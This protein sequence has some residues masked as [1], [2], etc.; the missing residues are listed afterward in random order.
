MELNCIEL[1]ADT[2]NYS[3]IPY[4]M[5]IEFTMTGAPKCG[6]RRLVHL[7]EY[8]KESILEYTAQEE[9]HKEGALG[10]T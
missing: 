10:Y 9:H 5:E 7:L 1:W 8:I 6:I 4:L 2:H 3:R